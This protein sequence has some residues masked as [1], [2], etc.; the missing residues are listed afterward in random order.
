MVSSPPSN[1]SSSPRNIILCFDGTGN[2]FGENSSVV[3]FFH[4]LVKDN[5]E[6]QLVYYQ[7]GIGTYNK[8]QFITRT[9][10]VIASV[11]DQGVALHL[12]DHVKEGYQFVMRNYRKGDRIFL[13]G[14]SRGAYTARV[15]LGMLYKIGILPAHN[16][17]QLD[18]AFSVY[19]TTGD[20]GYE[21]SK[22]FKRTFAMPVTVDFVG[23]WDTV[24][25]VGIIPRTHP[26]TSV[27]YAVKHFRH[28]LALDER[29]ARFRPNVW[30]EPTLEREQDLDTDEPD[31]IYPGTVSRDDWV[32]EPP[33]RDVCDVKEV[34]FSGCHADIGGGSHHNKIQDSLSHIP[35]RWM[36]K[37]C[38][39]NTE[40]L[41]DH[42]Y[43]KTLG[44]DLLDLAHDLADEGV[45]V[46]ARGFDNEALRAAAEEAK[47]LTYEKDSDIT[48]HPHVEA[49]SHALT[50][51][52]A[53]LPRISNAVVRAKMRADTLA[54]IW[55][56]LT[57]ARSWWVL[58]FMPMLVTYQKEDGTWIRKRMR[59][60]GQGRYMPFHEDKVQVH[61]S[62]KQRIE[63]TK[64]GEKPYTPS[65]YNWDIVRDSGMLT[66][67][68]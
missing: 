42:E 40:I 6:K 58:E 48:L 15:I 55:D 17:Q 56:Q 53:A 7:P 32:Y 41:F 54:M 9:V 2:K 50:T 62:V 27:N 5:P 4:A 35:L 38:F 26:Y 66:Y 63:E 30:N 8:R 61:I 28:A 67:V 24:S 31:V 64:D 34:W 22:E 25:S 44:F 47:A 23:V 14:F 36:I 45:D 18:F 51:F 19:Q 68:K 21:L 13:F 1:N 65:A 20:R 16:D 29:R 10:S 57:L 39:I 3:R 49:H 11:I 60:L 59:N 33:N 37:E 52:M 46:E 12:N 43:L